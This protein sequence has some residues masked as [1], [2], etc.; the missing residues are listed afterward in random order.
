MSRV[1]SIHIDQRK[2]VLVLKEVLNVGI[3][4]IGSLEA[5]AEQILDRSK[6]YS[7]THRTLSVD[8]AKLLKST[9][10]VVMSMRDDASMFANLLVLIRRQKKHRGISIIKPGSH[11]WLSIKEATKLA[12][13]FCND[14][15]LPKQEGIKIYIGM[16]LDRMSKFNISKFNSTHQWICEDYQ[17]VKEIEKDLTPKQTETVKIYYEKLLGE[18]GIVKD[19][20]KDPGKYIFFVRA[21]EEAN[22]QQVPLEVYVK[23]QF[24]AFEWCN[25]YPE[26]AQL[27]GTKSLDRLHKYL[28][29]INMKPGVI[30]K[31]KKEIELANELKNKWKNR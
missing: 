15:D 6:A 17:A 25:S 28:S 8:K 20:L 9:S 21:K 13:D 14:F 31:S 2:L 5:L 10:R 4:K 12:I 22:K 30:Q 11:Q 7:L 27:I 26:P 16:A 24:K 23:A 1:P 19:Y 18:K 29:E 3:N